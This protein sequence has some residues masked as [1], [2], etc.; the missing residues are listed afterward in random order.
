MTDL[1]NFLW[2]VF[3]IFTVIC[4][5]VCVEA[6]FRYKNKRGIDS[7]KGFSGKYEYFV[8]A[9]YNHEQVVS[10]YEL[11]LREFDQQSKEWRLP[12]NVAYFPLSKM[13]YAVQGLMPKLTG[14][15]RS[16]GL[17]MT[18]DQLI[19][20][21]AEYFFKWLLGVVEKQQIIV[22][23][24]A[25]NIAQSSFFQRRTMRRLLQIVKLPR[26][27]V[28]IEN[29]DSTHKTYRLLQPFLPNVDYLKFNA[30]AFEK[31]SNHWIDI[32][33]AQ[34]QRRLKRFAVTPI[35]GKVEDQHQVGLADQLQIELRQGYAFDRPQSLDELDEN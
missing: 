2:G 11:L 10:G 17:N 35:V 28:A 29:V 3:L 23:I 7:E 21:R 8:Q 12:R 30:T 4:L 14:E 25:Q 15:I 18:V 5:A 19:D 33:L 9:V 22:E 16:L 24:D 27:K 6:H 13:I 34:W 26:V 20:F 31:S 32:T 1:R